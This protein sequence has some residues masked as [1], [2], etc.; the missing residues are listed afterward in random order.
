MRPKKNLSKAAH[1]EFIRMNDSLV[2]FFFYT[3]V[4]ILDSSAISVQKLMIK[5]PCPMF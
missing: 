5:V 1:S 4:P 2:V 3:Y